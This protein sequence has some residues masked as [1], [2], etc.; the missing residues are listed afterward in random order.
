MEDINGDWDVVGIE[1]MSD[2]ESLLTCATRSLRAFG[3]ELAT[4]DRG[5][6]ECALQILQAQC[7]NKAAYMCSNFS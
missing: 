6:A 5:S 3:P 1:R 7:C 4:E 2:V